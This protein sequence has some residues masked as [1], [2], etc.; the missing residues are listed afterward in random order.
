MAR[1]DGMTPR[2]EAKRN[3]EVKLHDNYDDYDNYDN[4]K[5]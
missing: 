2:H 1:D 5:H 4:V 3:D